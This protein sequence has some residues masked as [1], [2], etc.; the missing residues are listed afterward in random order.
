[1]FLQSVVQLKI[2][3]LTSPLCCCFSLLCSRLKAVLQEWG[4]FQTLLA[5][6]DIYILSHP[7]APTRHQSSIFLL[8]SAMAHPIQFIPTEFSLRAISRR[9]LLSGG[10]WRHY[11]FTERCCC[12][13]TGNVGWWQI[14]SSGWTARGAVV[15]CTFSLFLVSLS[16]T[17]LKFFPPSVLT[18]T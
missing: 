2:N 17:L 14:S 16:F 15:N 6:W 8:K 9:L 1:M 10:E 5:D 11:F 4:F 7:Y 12:L 3:Q 13:G 18:S